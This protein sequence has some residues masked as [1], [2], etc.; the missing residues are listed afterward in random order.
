MEEILE[1]LWICP[2][3]S[4]EHLG[5]VILCHRCECQLLLLNKMKLIAYRLRHSGYEQ[6]S[7]RFYDKEI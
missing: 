2:L 3:C 5:P 7:R 1:T 6:L 4:A